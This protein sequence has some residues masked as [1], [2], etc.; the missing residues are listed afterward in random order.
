[1][2]KKIGCTTLGVAL[3]SVA[4]VTSMHA[5]TAPAGLVDFSKITGLKQGSGLVDV[6]LNGEIISLASK[7]VEKGQE[8][9]ATVLKGLKQIRIN[10]ISLKEDNREAIIETIKTLR[11]DL[12]GKGWNRIVSVQ[13]KN[14]DVAIFLKSRKDEAIEGLVLTVLSG[15]KEAVLINI[16]GDIKPEN[17]AMVAETFGIDP[18]KKFTKKAAKK[19]EI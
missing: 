7:F 9:L 6:N 19:S 14:D 12:D 5:D 2:L 15:N 3:L 4:L 11:T 1:M 17:L 18:L 8:E 16:V 13:E 10:V